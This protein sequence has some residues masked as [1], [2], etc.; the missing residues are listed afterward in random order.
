MIQKTNN[1]RVMSFKYRL[2]FLEYYWE[3]MKVDMSKILLSYTRDP[4]AAAKISSKVFSIK[5]ELKMKHLWVTGIAKWPMLI[6][7]ASP[8]ADTQVINI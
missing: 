5:P 6:S 3:N 8:H 7:C 1:I 2:T 4:E